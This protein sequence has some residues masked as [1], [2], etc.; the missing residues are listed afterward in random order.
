ME[1]M[2]GVLDFFRLIWSCFDLS[3]L[4]HRMSRFLFTFQSIFVVTADP[5]SLEMFEEYLATELEKSHPGHFCILNA[6]A[7]AGFHVSE[8]A[9]V[10]G[11]VG[12]LLFP[13]VMM[14]KTR[15]GV[16]VGGDRLVAEI[17]TVLARF[18]SIEDISFFGHSLGGIYCRYA[19]FE[20]LNVHRPES[21]QSIC[22]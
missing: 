3:K 9:S 6:H 20:L 7:N 4:H 2:V 14:H 13:A 16:D 21:T 1:S 19:G 18:E 22:P 8:D 17:E 12:N 15:D 5:I 11:W 10:F